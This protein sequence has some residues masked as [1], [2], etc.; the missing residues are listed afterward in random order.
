MQLTA[1]R[2]TRCSTV[3]A[4]AAA[5]LSGCSAADGLMPHIALPAEDAPTTADHPAAARPLPT[6]SDDGSPADSLVITEQQ[7]AFLDALAAGG[8]TPSD[9]LLALRIGSYVCQARAAHQ[10]PQ[11]V[12]DFIEPLVSSDVRDGM[13]VP[14]SDADVHAATYNYIRIATKRLC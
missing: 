10:P 5:V 14:P 6:S 4:V 7:Q 8:L 1:G 2:V 9:E 11:A 3:M 13:I 12:W